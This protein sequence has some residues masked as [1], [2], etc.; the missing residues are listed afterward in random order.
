MITLLRQ[1]RQVCTLHHDQFFLQWRL[2]TI[3]CSSGCEWLPNVAQQSKLQL[4]VDEL[5]HKIMDGVAL[6][7]NLII[8]EH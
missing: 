8:L 5:V 4:K 1:W 6:L 7:A 2:N 3:A